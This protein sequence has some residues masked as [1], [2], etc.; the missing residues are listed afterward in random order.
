MLGVAR[1]CGGSNPPPP[2]SR[3]IRE[4]RG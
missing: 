4:K 3:C 1:T 2:D